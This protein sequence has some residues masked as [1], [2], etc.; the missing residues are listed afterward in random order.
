VLGLLAKYLLAVADRLAMPVI[1][2]Q[3]LNLGQIVL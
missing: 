1:G 3:I 2:Y